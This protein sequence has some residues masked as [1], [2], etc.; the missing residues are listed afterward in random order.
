ME[1]KTIYVVVDKETNKE[2]IMLIGDWGV[3]P[4]FV[5]LK[6]AMEFRKGKYY[7][8]DYKVTKRKLIY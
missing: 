8:Q 7:P 1:E 6:D 2:D 5:K 3:I 4:M